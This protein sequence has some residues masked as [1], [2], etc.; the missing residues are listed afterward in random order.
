MTNKKTLCV[1]FSLILNVIPHFAV[2]QQTEEEVRLSSVTVTAQ[3]VEEDLQEVPISITTI[4]DEKLD[5]LKGAGADVRFLSARI[6]SVIAESS[7]GRAFPRFYIRG[8]GNTD[9]DLNATQPVSLVYDD[10]PYE[11]PILKGFPVF[12]LESIEVLRGPQGTLFGRNT[13]GGIIKFDSVKPSSK[14]GGYSR[15]SYGNYGTIEL[16]GAY[17]S[18][19]S[20]DAAYRVSGIVQHRDHYVD[21]AHTKQKNAYEGFDEY[22]FRVQLSYAASDETSILLNVHTRDNDSTARLFRA[23]IIDRGTNGVGKTFDRKKVYLDSGAQEL[24]QKTTGTTITVDHKMSSTTGLTYVFGYETAEVSSRGDIDGGYGA[25]GASSPDSGPGVIP[26]SSESGG[27]VNDLKQITHELRFEFLPDTGIKGQAGLFV[28]QE[29]IDIT[30]LSFNSLHDGSPKNGE[31]IRTNETESFGAFASISYDVNESLSL[32][33]GLRSTSDDK[34]FV[35]ERTQSPIGQGTKGPIRGKT[36]DSQISWDFSALYEVNDEVN[37]YFRVARGYRGPSIQGRLVF[38]DNVSVADSETVI[39]WEAG[40]KSELFDRRLRA[41]ANLFAYTIKDQQLT[42]V[43][44]QS[45]TV[46]L[47]NADEGQGSGFE[48]DIEAAPANNLFLTAG[49]S[50]NKTEIKDDLLLSPGC[51][52]PVNC[53]ILDPPVRNSDD[54][55][56]GYNI[57]GNPFPNAPKWIANFTARYSYQDNNGEYYA[58]TDLA[59]KGDTNFFLYESK[60]Y[61]QDGYW[62]IGLRVGFKSKRG[63]DVSLFARNLTDYE[64]LTGGID[65]NNLTGYVNEPRTFGITLDFDI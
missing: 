34:S 38:G 45:N 14:T 3:R 55:I 20:E 29:D 12:D 5:N 10:V 47:F 7:F 13:P 52:A 15:T 42:V 53:T 28:F 16:E 8:F 6:P 21:N 39:S 40:I 35:V 33:G 62:E 44:G 27:N 57:S 23:N 46:A 43:G 49:L 65:F 24:K 31:A 9:F 41:N 36:D 11:N 32:S 56:I 25:V 4:S 1:A 30:S 63:Y 50:Y 60:E 26:F 2:G 61:S 17:G 48:V 54:E 51:G 37:A 22:A 59:F 19:I 58:Y 18:S 64:A